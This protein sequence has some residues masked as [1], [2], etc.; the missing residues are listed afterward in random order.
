M[1]TPILSAPTAARQSSKRKIRGQSGRTARPRQP[2]RTPLELY[3]AYV[4]SAGP[5]G[6]RARESAQLLG[7]DKDR[8]ATQA[9]LIGLTAA[10]EWPLPREVADELM[11]HEPH[12]AH[13]DPTLSADVG[14]GFSSEPKPRIWPLSSPIPL[15]ER[16]QIPDHRGQQLPPA[17]ALQRAVRHATAYGLLPPNIEQ[18]K[19]RKSGWTGK[20]RLVMGVCYN[21]SR[22]SK[23]GEFTL[24][25]RQVKELLGC[26]D[27]TAKRV[28]R[29]IEAAGVI[30]VAPGRCKG[31]NFT[32]RRTRFLWLGIAEQAGAAA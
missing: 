15:L 13:V 18:L 17:C 8:H 24:G 19:T 27:S 20:L 1:S 7:V 31:N 30:Q 29:E 4:D 9:K 22:R 3:A 26:S 23:D 28:I 12:P 5:E 25:Y 32:K 16:G 14:V 10:G 2:E 21:L 6:E 11:S